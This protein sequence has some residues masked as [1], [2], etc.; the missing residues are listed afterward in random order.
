MADTER[1]AAWSILV[2]RTGGFAGIRREWRVSSADDASVDWPA[3]IEA[4]PWRRRYPPSASKDRFVWRIEAS[5]PP[6]IVRRI[7]LP[8]SAVVGPWRELA[9]RV[10]DAAAD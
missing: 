3:L 2:V 1:T 8:E 5:A 9:D 10:R 7:T 6:R 4:C